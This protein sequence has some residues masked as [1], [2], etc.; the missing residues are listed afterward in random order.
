M[1]IDFHTHA[2][3]SKKAD[4]SIGEFERMIEE[5]KANGL[6]ATALTEHFNTKNFEGIYELLDQHYEYK[7]EYYDVNGFKVFAGIEIDILETGHILFVG[8]RN[9]IMEV[10]E[11]LLPHHT[12]DTFIEVKALMEFSKRYNLIRIGAHPLRD[13]TPLRHLEP[14]ILKSFDFFDLNA[15]DL[16][17]HGIKMKDEVESFAKTYGVPVIA[18]SDTHHF[19][20]FGAVMNSLY[21]ECSTVSELKDTLMEGK[22]EMIIS[23]CLNTKVKAAKVVKSILKEK[24]AV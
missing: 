23:P 19:L 12:E 3:L 18:G 9:D 22:Y 4:F 20:Q 15:K 6:T 16:Y 17:Q 24:L 2:K 21:A 5:A 10:H 8:S 7:Q 1:N 11:F 14:D 13:T